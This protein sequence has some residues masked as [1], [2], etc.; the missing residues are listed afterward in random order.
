MA[1]AATTLGT[2]TVRR[3]LPLL[4]TLLLAG[5]QSSYFHAAAPAPDEPIRLQL[6]ELPYSE[7]WTGLVFNG[8]K[9]GFTRRSLQRLP[10][11]DLRYEIRSEASF[12]LR[13]LGIEKRIHLKARD[14]VSGSLQL[15]DFQYD[16]RIDG[17]ELAMTGRRDQD[18]LE[19]SVT[20]RENVSRFRTRLDGALYPSSA[21]ALYPVM[22][23]LMVGREYRYRVY[24]GQLQ[25]IAQ[26]TQRV[27]RYE[28]S[29]FFAGNAF[30]ILTSMHGQNTTT[31]IDHSGRPA[32]ELAMRGAMISALEDEATARQYVAR[33]ALNRQEALIELSLVRP[34]AD[35]PAPR[36]V[37]Y[38]KAEISGLD[39]VPPSAPAQHCSRRGQEIECEIRA[40][41]MPGELPSAAAADSAA[42]YLGT[43]PTVQ[44][45][46]ISI[47][48]VAA[49]IADGVM[50]PAKRVQKVIA[51][52]QRNIEKAPLDVFSALDVLH[53]RK[54][55]CQGHAYLYTALARA[56]G[57]P[58][59]MVS[60]LVYS[61]DLKG[62][63]FHSWAES[64]V[65]NRWVAVDP[66]FGQ[67]SADATH[68]RLLEGEALADLLPLA[69]WVGRLKIR[70]LA[71]RHGKPQAAEN[72][73]AAIW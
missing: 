14:L 38:M 46:H 30:R 4:L 65:G 36:K 68:I 50:E 72:R 58:T 48:T 64:M 7:Y 60:G 6:H 8:E 17:S 51:W 13:F 63:L 41:G 26:V 69:R 39:G 12:V 21:I 57:I 59:R 37:V 52:M 27:D 33:A 11:N 67:T 35:V 71:L 29:A 15:L 10:G 32:F 28:S 25:T 23:G 49:E 3:G 1:M 62:F 2:G 47:R 20:N 18:M 24:D 9:I 56:L 16:Y 31:W 70:V 45:S 40:S 66:T 34:E 55:E 73:S 44:S 61:E 43:S 5:C 22:H 19:V 54:A 42:K 53:L